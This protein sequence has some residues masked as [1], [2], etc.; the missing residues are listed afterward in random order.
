MIVFCVSVNVVPKLSPQKYTP[1]E[2]QKKRLEAIKKLEMKKMT[3]L[4][5]KD[6]LCHLSKGP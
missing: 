1:E 2:I 6:K 4:C 5:E 3:M